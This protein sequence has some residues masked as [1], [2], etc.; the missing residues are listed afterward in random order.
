MFFCQKNM[1]NYGIYDDFFLNYW[2]YINSITIFSNEYNMYTYHGRDICR[3]YK[4]KI[5]EGVGRKNIFLKNKYCKG[6][7]KIKIKIPG[8]RP[9]AKG[10]G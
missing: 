6:E 5:N 9:G 7:G 1:G 2:S 8:G 4:S 10:R 3:L